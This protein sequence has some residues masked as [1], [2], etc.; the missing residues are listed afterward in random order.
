M[1]QSHQPQSHQVNAEHYDRVTAAWSHLL[2]E[3]LHY[4]LFATGTED[5]SVATAALTER[6][7]RSARLES[8]L[9]V[10]DVGCGTGAPAVA[11]ATEFGVDVLGISTSEVGVAAAS[12]RAAR[13]G[14]ADTVRFRIAD[15]ADNRLPA[16]SFDRVWVLESSHL[17]AARE[18]LVAGCAQVLRPG[19]RI[20][21]CD[22]IRQREIPM[23]EIRSR[24][25]EFQVLRDAFGEARME[26]L[27]VYQELMTDAG[28]VVDDVEDLTAA[29]RPT[30]DRWRSNAEANTESRMLLGD[31]GYDAFVESTHVLES[32]WDDGLLG[33]GIIGAHKPPTA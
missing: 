14:L 24:L 30:F 32:M 17:M 13:H 7:A 11:I 22:I 8:G 1:S 16:A 5:L 12:E 28:L 31:E 25:H 3:E 10:L 4:G 23:L 29:T 2:G 20:A 9:E 18:R 26:T 21:L 33:Y 19:G 15:G 6:M 27:D